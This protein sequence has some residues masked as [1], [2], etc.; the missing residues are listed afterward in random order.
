MLATSYPL[1]DAFLTM[2]WI[3]GFVLWI[4]LVI[5]VF[6]DIFRSRDLSGWGKAGWTLAVFVLPLFG[7]LLYLI[8]RGHK[9]RQRA[10]DEALANE[11]ATRQ[12]IRKVA[13]NP[14]TSEDLAKLTSLRDSGAITQAEFERMKANL[15]RPTDMQQ[16]S[17]S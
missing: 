3:V 6:V 11:L 13:A 8:V 17:M 9:M 2:L 4:W 10:E 5:A 16:P 14:D 1:L 7:V 15:Q 12:Y